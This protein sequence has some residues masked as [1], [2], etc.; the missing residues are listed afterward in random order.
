MKTEHAATSAIR[1]LI[2]LGFIFHNIGDP[3]APDVIF[4][5]CYRSS[6]VDLVKIHGHDEAEAER[7]VNGRQEREI[8]GNPVEVVN[9]IAGWPN[10]GLVMVGE[11]D[12]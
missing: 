11:L 2:A 4:C 12:D 10:G 5:S 8:S 1:K 9:Q 7:L 6:F 3:V